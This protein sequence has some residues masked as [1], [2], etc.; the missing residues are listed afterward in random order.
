MCRLLKGWKSF[1][2]SRSNLKQFSVK[3]EEGRLENEFLYVKI[4]RAGVYFRNVGVWKGLSFFPIYSLL[5][6]LFIVQGDDNW[7]NEISK[8]CF[9]NLSCF[10]LKCDVG[11]S[12]KW[13]LQ[14]S[15][16]YDFSKS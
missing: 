6:D 15:F 3:L 8:F 10:M 2:W 4:A 16:S 11:A 1:N 12:L 5:P 13:G 9:V 7:N 14:V